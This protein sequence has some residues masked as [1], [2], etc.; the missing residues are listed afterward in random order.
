MR[1]FYTISYLLHFPSGTRFFHEWHIFQS[2]KFSSPDDILTNFSYDT[3]YSDSFRCHKS[4]FQKRWLPW[5]LMCK[6]AIE[7]LLI[8]YMIKQKTFQNYR[9]FLTSIDMTVWQMI[10]QIFVNRHQPSHL[11]DCQF[12]KAKSHPLLFPV[13]RTLHPDMHKPAWGLR[14]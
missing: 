4:L 5:I 10:L 14:S 2:N 8:Y 11:V 12:T 3:F 9:T 7:V 1:I 6:T 13:P